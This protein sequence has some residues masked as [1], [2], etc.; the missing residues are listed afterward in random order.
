MRQLLYCYRS[1]LDSYWCL[2]KNTETPTDSK[3]GCS[4]SETNFSKLK[5]NAK[6]MFSRST[7]SSFSG[8]VI[9]NKDI[10]LRPNDCSCVESALLD[11][12]DVELN[13]A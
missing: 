2:K 9:G 10:F 5:K 1:R 4:L 13:A 6:K 12:S 3:F 11:C 7:D 8:Y